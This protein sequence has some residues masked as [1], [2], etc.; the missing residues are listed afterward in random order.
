M[1]PDGA[2]RALAR[3]GKRLAVGDRID[4]GGGLTA[5]VQDKDGAEVLLGFD[6]DGAALTAALEAVGE[7]PLPPYIAARRPADAADRQ[8]YQTVFAARPGAVAAPT[9]SLHFDAGAPRRRSRR[10][11]WRGPS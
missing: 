1:P 7:M 11:G 4:F 5:E 10:G 6:R 8:D 9:A 2:W 3:P